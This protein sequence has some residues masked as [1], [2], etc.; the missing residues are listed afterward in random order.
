MG[1]PDESLVV[2]PTVFTILHSPSQLT[3]RLCGP[4]GSSSPLQELC[5]PGLESRAV[6]QVVQALTG[7]VDVV[8][9]HEAAVTGR[10]LC[11]EADGDGYGRVVDGEEADHPPG[12]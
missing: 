4:P 9:G 10:R 8:E 11:L 5:S 2:T 6:A 3:R 7:E 1:E 12:L